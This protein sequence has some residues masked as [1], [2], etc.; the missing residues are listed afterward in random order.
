M[1]NHSYNTK[2]KAYRRH[3]S[4]ANQEQG[5]TACKEYTKL[6]THVRN[7]SWNQ[8]ITK[9]NNNI[10]S[11][12]VWRRI[13]AA[14]KTAPRPPTHH[15][16][17]EEADSPCDSFAQRCSQENLP[18]RTNNILT[19]LVPERVRTITT[20]TYEAVDTD[21][22]LTI[23]GLEDVLDCLNVTAPGEDTVCYSM[24]KN[25]LLSTR[26]LFFRLINQSFP[27]GRLPSRCKMAKIIPVPKKGKM[28]RPISLPPAFSKVMERLVQAR[29]KWSD[30][31]FNPNSLGFRSGVVTID[32][33]ATLIT[34]TYTAPIAALRRGYNSRSVIIFLDLEKIVNFG[35]LPQ[36]W[37]ALGGNSY[38]R[39]ECDGGEC[40][41]WAGSIGKRKQQYCWDYRK[42]VRCQKVTFILVLALRSKSTTFGRTNLIH[43]NPSK[44]L[45]M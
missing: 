2:L 10:D 29:V 30:K 8:W 1:E 14:K 44:L 13:K 20:A 15:R 43:I 38:G 23:S 42:L 32:A 24:I 9:C 25:T 35:G 39:K 45:L 33:I 34:N 26:H 16:P 17:Q 4:P 12:E 41:K 21:Q 37:D 11:A 3:A 5:Q 6:C 22:E 28:H 40:C 18:E 19:N 36:K 31:P 7:I 27:E